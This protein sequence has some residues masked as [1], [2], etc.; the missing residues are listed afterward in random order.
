MQHSQRSIEPA[1]AQEELK[2]ARDATE[3]Q[4]LLLGSCLAEAHQAF[5]AK[6][7]A[8]QQKYGEFLSAHALQNIYIRYE[9]IAKR[10]SGSREGLPQVLLAVVS[11]SAYRI[12]YLAVIACVLECLAG[13]EIGRLEALLAA[14][15]KE[16]T[17]ARKEAAQHIA[18]STAQVLEKQT[19]ARTD[20]RACWK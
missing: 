7:R 12:R 6:L 16:L 9:I 1:S 3:G 20:C 11:S 4:E 13:E 17:A 19:H 15:A 8:A 2:S 14:A 10:L 5:D 18:A